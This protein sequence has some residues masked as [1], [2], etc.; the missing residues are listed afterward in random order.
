[1]HKFTHLII[2]GIM[3]TINSNYYIYYIRLFELVYNVHLKMVAH[4]LK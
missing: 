1:M 2:L 3:C 4:M